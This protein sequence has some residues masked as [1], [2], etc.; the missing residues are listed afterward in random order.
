MK[1]CLIT[2]LLGM[3]FAQTGCGDDGEGSDDTATTVAT[4]STNADDTAATATATATSGPTT[5]NDDADTGGSADA[6]SSDESGGDTGVVMIACGD[7]LVCTG[8]EVCIHEL[9][10]PECTNYDPKTEMCPVDQQPSSCGGAGIPCCCGATP[11]PVHSCF[12]ASECPGTPD[13][14]CLGDV[15]TGGKECQGVIS[16][17]SGE[18]NCALPPPP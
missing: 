17:T 12:V 2:V 7:D 10:E 11:P 6:S 13:C 16:K 18:F 15:C 8:D 5:G 1:S 14:E 3:A 4:G 9:F